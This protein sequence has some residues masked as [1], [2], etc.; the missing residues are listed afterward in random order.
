MDNTHRKTKYIM[1][2]NLLRIMAEKKVRPAWLVPVAGKNIY[3]YLNGSVGIND[4]AIDMLSK[5]LQVDPSEFLQPLEEQGREFIGEASGVVQPVKGGHFDTLY[6]GLYP[7]QDI[8]AT[9]ATAK[10]ND[11]LA[12]ISAP[13]NVQ[14]FKDYYFGEQTLEKVGQTFSITKERVRQI[15]SDVQHS[16]TT[17][18]ACRQVLFGEEGAAGVITTES[19]VSALGGKIE[20]IVKILLVHNINTVGDV[21]SAFSTG[22]IDTIAA[23][24]TN[25]INTLL[26]LLNANGID[27]KYERHETLPKERRARRRHRHVKIH[28]SEKAIAAV[29]GM[30]VPEVL[31]KAK[32]E[33]W[34][35]DNT[36]DG[37]RKYVV[38]ELPERVRNAFGPLYTVSMISIMAKFPR[39]AV[40]E[41]AATDDWPRV[42]VTG[43]PGKCSTAVKYPFNTLPGEIKKA[44]IVWEKYS[45]VPVHVRERQSVSIGAREQQSE[46]AVVREGQSGPSA[47]QPS[48][49]NVFQLSMDELAMVKVMRLRKI[50]PDIVTRAIINIRPKEPANNLISPK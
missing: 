16:L 42:E 23:V 1:Q 47:V 4:K 5:A 45:P 43:L 9:E 7:L 36:A 22:K 3:R 29:L 17:V 50:P 49:S 24:G 35:T 41:R 25:K 15:L 48:G 44:I 27:V 28:C 13:R 34:A 39:E 26:D 11:A 31:E 8:S 21:V 19:P 33:N 40:R 6:Q 32:N 30:T 38:S 37:S 14:I 46:P 10:I 2:K 18:P 12:L 20:N